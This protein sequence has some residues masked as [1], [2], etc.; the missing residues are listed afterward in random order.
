[1][2]DVSIPW[3][4]RVRRPRRDEV[5]ARLIEAAAEVIAQQGF[6]GA[7]VEEVS[8]RAGFSRGAFYSNFADK[9]ELFMEVLERHTAER[10]AELEQ[11][12]SQQASPEEF[13]EALRRFLDRRGV[14][15][16]GR[17]EQYMG[18]WLHAAAQPAL[19]SQMARLERRRQAIFAGA[20]SRVLASAGLGESVDYS[21]EWGA[22][23]SALDHGT[24]LQRL[25]VQRSTTLD[26]LALITRLV[27][28]IS[29]RG[30]PVPPRTRAS[31]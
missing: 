12:L 29:S 25:L 20:A 8:A 19:R 21:R 14:G 3:P 1:M 2:S 6:G 10:V 7:S 9:D 30:G 13:A 15:T 17:F 18:L 28:G 27:L 5:R 11:A 24:A 16:R 22:V 4:V 26:S 31:G 23:L